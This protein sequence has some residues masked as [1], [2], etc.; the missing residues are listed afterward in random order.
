MKKLIYLLFTLLC[1]ITLTACS[2]DDENK[3]PSE[4]VGKWKLVGFAENG[5]PEIKTPQP[6]DC[7]ECY[8]LKFRKDGTFEGVSSINS[9][10]GNFTI[11]NEGKSI[12]LSPYFITQI[13][14]AGDGNL[15]VQCFRWIKFYSFSENNLEFYYNDNEYLIFKQ[16][17]S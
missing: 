12:N 13:G 6:E 8:T 4:I 17:E 11:N 3:I 14:E 7:G 10:S 2:D 15:Y 9:M 1:I 5:N 16:I